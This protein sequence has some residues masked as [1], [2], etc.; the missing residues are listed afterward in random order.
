MKITAISAPMGADF[1]LNAAFKIACDTLT[2]TGDE[3]KTYNLAAMNLGFFDEKKAPH[4]SEIMQ[5][6][7]TSDGVIF[8]FSTA[9]PAPSALLISFFEFF[10]DIAFRSHLK[11]KPCLIMAVSQKGVERAALEVAG[12]MLTELGGFDAVRVALNP[13]VSSIV[14]N[15]VIELI[16]R[17]A[18]DFYRIL[19]QNRKYI[20]PQQNIAIDL[21][22]ALPQPKSIN[23][24]ELY[25]KHGLDNM[26]AQQ[27][28]DIA[29]ISSM[30]AKKFISS[31]GQV[32]ERDPVSLTAPK[33]SAG[34]ST[35]QLTATLPHRF[36]PHLAKDMQ[37]T[38]QLNITGSGGF[39]GYLAITPTD[40]SFHE[41]APDTSD[42]IVIADAKAWNDVL[43]KKITAQK[44]FMMGQLKVRGN[45]VLLTNFDQM[46]NAV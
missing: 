13:A 39:E 16:E 23:V 18:E 40:C 3:V 36:N 45:F 2:E 42:I 15:D 8:A 28:E 30:F 27:Q 19:R 32:K 38:I 35:K 1:G 31:D 26:T 20:L 43:T 4:A 5:N 12:G 24:N 37:A 33:P 17:Q 11:N 7:D 34:R 29:K 46:F 25:E 21:E 10:T 9:F 22:P 44:A 41:G 14:Q 6:I